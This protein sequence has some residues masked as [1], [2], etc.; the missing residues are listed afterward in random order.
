[1]WMVFVSGSNGMASRP[2]LQYGSENKVVAMMNGTLIV[3]HDTASDNYGSPIINFISE[4]TYRIDPHGGEGGEWYGTIATRNAN[5]G[6]V[7]GFRAFTSPKYIVDSRINSVAMT[8]LPGAPIDSTTGLPTPTIAVGTAGGVSVIMNDDTI[9]SDGALGLN[10][11]AREIYFQPNTSNI[12]FMVNNNHHFWADVNA[13]TLNGEEISSNPDT[14]IPMYWPYW[15]GEDKAV[16]TSTDRVRVHSSG[17]T[18]Y[19]DY[20]EYSPTTSSVLSSVAY[21]TSKYNTGYMTGDIRGGWNVDTDTTTFPSMDGMTTYSLGGG[22]TGGITGGILDVTSSSVSNECIRIPFSFVK[23]KFYTLTATGESGGNGMAPYGLLTTA[24]AWA[25]TVGSAGTT[26]TRIVKA[27]YTGSSFAL[28][29]GGAYSHCVISALTIKEA[30]PDRARYENG[31]QVIG[32]PTV[33]AVATGAELK[34]L[35]NLNGTTDYVIKDFD[36]SLDFGTGDFSCYVWL[37]PDASDPGDKYYHM[38]NM[39][40]GTQSGTGNFSLK[41]WSGNWMPYAYGHGGTLCNSSISLSPGSWNMIV[42]GRKNSTFFMYIN[43]VDATLNPSSTSFNMGNHNLRVGSSSTNTG[44]NIPGNIIALPRLSATA[45][46]AKQVKEIY[47]AEKPLFQENA[48]CTLDGTSDGVTA[49]SYDDSNEELLVGTSTNLSVFKG[50]RRV[51]ENDNNISEVA[52]QGGL[53]VE[54][55]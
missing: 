28:H 6:Q 41:V 49:I 30:V 37:K 24:N 20:N 45:P 42:C 3:G 13:T 38:I 46:I 10:G 32:N 5:A 19:K 22:A 15:T 16:H 1:M 31:M 27:D 17:V 7:A 39:T 36:A 47:E 18:F 29:G 43:G 26:T 34:G 54:E 50:L 52:Q 51:D 53:R 14:A 8:V 33:S 25:N 48:K 40:A 12:F 4:Y 23:G 21:M 2:M 35:T 9:K 55:Y 44:E 11:I